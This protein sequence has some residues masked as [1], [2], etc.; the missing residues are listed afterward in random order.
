[1][2][3][4]LQLDPR[5]AA[6]RKAQGAVVAALERHELLRMGLLPQGYR[7]PLFSRYEQGMGFGAHV[8]DATMRQDG[9]AVRT[10]VSLTVF[11]SEP[12]EYD[13]GELVTD[14]TAGEQRY[15]LEAGSVIAHP[16]TTLHRVD[17]VTR[18]RRD[19]A[20]TWAQSLVREPGRREV[21]FDLDTARR[22]LFQREGKSR[23]FDLLSKTYSNLLRLWAEP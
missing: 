21:L 22:S 5:G 4:N 11:L 20:V 7:T 8:D 6:A 13:G 3:E 10:D 9:A 17:P 23:E 16:S 19:V 2:K 18:G 12:A 14:T 15:K 1:M